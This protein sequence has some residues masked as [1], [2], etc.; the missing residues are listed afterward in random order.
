MKY[1]FVARIYGFE[2]NRT[3][4]R[5]IKIIEN[6]RLSTNRERIERIGDSYFQ[7]AIG[8]I[9]YHDL[10]NGPYVYV[11]GDYD[12]EAEVVREKE[13]LELLNYYMRL[14]QTLGTAL[15]GVKDNSVRTELGFIYVYD[16][17]RF[18]AKATSVSSNA[19]T[20]YFFNSH[21]GTASTTF[22]YDELLEGV[23]IHNTFY[24]ETTANLEHSETVNIVTTKANRIERFI[25]F[26]QSARN[27]AFLPNRISSYCTA[28]ETLFSTDSQEISHK[29]SERIARILGED[30]STREKIYKFIKNAY[31]IRSSN[32]HGDKLPR[33]F[34]S[35]E[36]QIQ[37]SEELDDCIRKLYN[38]IIH[39]DEISGIYIRDNKDELN[40]YFDK[41]I[42]S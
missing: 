15:W 30:F 14:T 23:S 36:K 22:S 34:R 38:F 4:N 6:L 2:V 16:E 11:E 41:L 17:R 21:G 1:F 7:R 18:D 19:R 26:L 10:L 12:I 39:D 31:T 32:V 3:L 35:L 42:L 40:H 5:G 37:V 33:K 9:E 29:I 27:Q 28:L 20:S 8:D 13:R 24:D 25:Y